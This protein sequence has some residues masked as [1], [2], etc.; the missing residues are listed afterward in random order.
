MFFL[1]VHV[2]FRFKVFADYEAYIASQEKVNELYK[3]CHKGAVSHYDLSKR[4]L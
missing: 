1:N 3:V 2:V 4:F